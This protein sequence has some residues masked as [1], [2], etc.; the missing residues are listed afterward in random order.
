MADSSARL[1]NAMEKAT[2]PLLEDHLIYRVNDADSGLRISEEVI[3]CNRP[4]TVLGCYE[5]LDQALSGRGGKLM[6]YD[7]RAEEVEQRLSED[8]RE[9][10]RLGLICALLGIA[11]CPVAPLWPMFT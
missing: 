4:V 9:N 1:L 7:G 11:A 5:A 2:P 6:V 10:G 8:M 3:P